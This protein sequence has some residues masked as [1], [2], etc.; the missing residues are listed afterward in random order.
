M[1]AG[2]YLCAFPADWMKRKHAAV[3]FNDIQGYTSLMQENEA[4]AIR[5]RQRHKE[6]V[7][8]LTREFRG[9][10]IQYYGDG[11]LTVFDEPLDAVHCALNMQR[12][13]S[14]SPRT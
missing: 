7:D 9:R 8:R 6:V 2:P 5:I 1:P 13:C 10:I 12:E 14:Q 3:V 4:H 11:T